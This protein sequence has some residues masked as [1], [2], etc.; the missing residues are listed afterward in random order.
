MLDAMDG[1]VFQREVVG[2]RDVPAEIG[3]VHGKPCDGGRDEP[4]N[5]ATSGARRRSGPMT[6]D[7]EC[8]KAA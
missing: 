7:E 5:D 4:V 8:G 3:E 1:F 6:T 2:G